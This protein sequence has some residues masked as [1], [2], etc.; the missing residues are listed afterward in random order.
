MLVLTPDQI[1]F[2]D[3]R[4]HFKGFWRENKG[5]DRLF[6]EKMKCQISSP[7]F[8]KLPLN[9]SRIGKNQ[10]YTC[11]ISRPEIVKIITLQWMAG[12]THMAKLLVQI[13]ESEEKVIW[14]PPQTTR[15]MRIQIKLWF[16]LIMDWL[17]F[18]WI[19]WI[20]YGP[21]SLHCKVE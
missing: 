16:L 5:W 21:L 18:F 12:G 20:Y 1:D 13:P 19:E 8:N 4:S 10:T 6:G 11:S 14:F 3:F 17:I 15:T 7:E 9:F 2:W